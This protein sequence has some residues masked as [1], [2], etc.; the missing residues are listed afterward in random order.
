MIRASADG[1]FECRVTSAGRHGRPRRQDSKGSDAGEGE[2][3][4]FME[5]CFGCGAETKTYVGAV[6][7]C[8]LCAEKCYGGR[9]PQKRSPPDVPSS[10]RV[11]CKEWRTLFE[12]HGA[13]L[14]EHFG[15]AARVVDGQTGERANRLR[16]LANE[17]LDA[18]HTSEMDLRRHEQEHGCRKHALGSATRA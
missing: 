16:S 7:I 13:A 12:R 3:G 15:A 18:V 6:P 11:T 10:G 8:V 14:R 4:P 5:K 1:R 17:A 9:K 2:R